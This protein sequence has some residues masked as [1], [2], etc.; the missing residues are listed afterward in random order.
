MTEAQKLA[1]RASE[2]RERLNAIQG[3]GE[4]PADGETVEGLASELTET[5]KR[6]REA[7]KAEAAEP[8]RNGDAEDG[9]SVELRGLVERSSVTRF[10]VAAMRS[11][12][13]DGAEAELLD[14]L[15]VRSMAAGEV[16]VPWELL[17]PPDPERR[18]DDVTAPTAPATGA[19][20]VGSAPILRRVFAR[21]DAG[22]LG[23]SMPGVPAGARSYPVLSAGVTAT[24]P[25]KGAAV[26]ANAV[27]VGA[28]SVVTPK[29]VTG[30]VKFRIEDLAT[31]GADLEGA[32]REDVLAAVRDRMDAEIVADLFA[33]LTDPDKPTA[34][35]TFEDAIAAAAAAVDGIYANDEGAVRML[36]GTA[37]YG[38]FAALFR[39]S[40]G[41]SVSASTYLRE[42]T[43]G[44]RASSRVPAVASD[45][46]QAV[47]AA[48]PMA[49]EAVYP[50]WTGAG[51]ALVRDMYSEARSGIISLTANALTG[52]LHVVR[53]A[54]W[55]QVAFQ[56][57]GS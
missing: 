25:N 51:V 47:T 56:V 29:R 52:G 33:A 4:D 37:T 20:G 39:D 45:V 10:A 40:S 32:L 9:Q 13:V 27:T 55:R 35:V 43:G 34:L 49:G 14:A 57:T 24:E 2:I 54:P 22:F 38:K 21:S 26:D 6:W 41:D 23:V 11:R 48:M 46:Q 42:R 31:F 3:G 17:A 7:V 50:V 5:E 36:V 28:A 12:D 8:S 30:R 15:E 18:A 1:I 44:L 53:S 19:W 16:V